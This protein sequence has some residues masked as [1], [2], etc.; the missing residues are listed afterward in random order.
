[1]RKSEA[2]ELFELAAKSG[3]V[4]MEAL[5]T[6]YAPG[7]L[8]LL[9]IAKT[10]RLGQIRDVEASFTKLV[11]PSTRAREYD[12]EVGGSFTELASYPLLPI[13]KLLGADYRDL[14]FDYYTG[15]NGVDIY[16]KAHFTYDGAVACA[17]TGIGVKSE[18]Q[19]LVSGTNG[20]IL[21]KSPWWLLK[22]F[23]V[24][25]ENPEDNEIFSAAFPGYGMRL[26]VAD[27]IHN[28]S[29]PATRNYKLRSADS[30]E[31]AGIIER[32]LQVRND[33]RQPSLV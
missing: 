33:S 6:A 16:T 20:Y 30:I 11:P 5:K 4:L 17:K 24:C 25:Y 13:L 3:L 32:F 2:R 18:G 19:L 26:E 28:I 31:M 12:P 14:R 7:F 8:N 1:L 9:A 21:V 10:G 27:F 22:S 15:A 23:E 29:E